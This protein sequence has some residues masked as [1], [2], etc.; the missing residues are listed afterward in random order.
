MLRN[1]HI[2]LVFESES[3]GPATWTMRWPGRGRCQEGGL[4]GG[5]AGRSGLQGRGGASLG[6]P[7]AAL[8][9]TCKKISFVN[10]P[11]LND[12]RWLNS[13]VL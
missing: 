6:P 12:L 7:T 8:A 2:L 11:P 9:G 5:G 3:S 1:V 13:G 10:S 4:V